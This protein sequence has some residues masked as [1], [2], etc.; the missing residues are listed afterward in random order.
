MADV[1]PPELPTASPAPA[2]SSWAL[3]PGAEI[4][5]G[6]RAVRRLGGGTLFEVYRAWD[7]RRL[8]LVVCKMVRPDQVGDGRALRQL[9]R[10]SGLLARLSHPV[11]VRSLGSVL[12]GPRPHLIL[13]H[14][15]KATLRRRLRVRGPL[16]VERVLPL[17]RQLGAALH[18]LSTQ[19]VVHLDVKPSNVLLGTPP[20]LIDLSIARSIDRARRLQG[21]V[22]TTNYMAPEQCLPAEHGPVGAAA[23]VWGLG[24]TVY[25]ALA[26]RLPFRS[27]ASGD[28]AAPS[29]RYPQ[30]S[31]AARP[32]PDTFP[33]ALSNL[34]MRCLQ[35]DPASRPTT[36]EFIAALAPI[37][38]SLPGGP[39]EDWPAAPV[40][41]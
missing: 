20:R 38:A 8:S 9:R 29:D 22:G 27:G 12:E 31:A 35:R 26:G 2:K 18:Y 37:A 10:E 7:E 1:A 24:V 21:P 14:I 36:G 41:R 16:P 5:P 25:E 40:V 13:E 15:E 32:L 11:I 6:F 3:A 17:A 34:V 33:L 39:L 4:A 19:D 28:E 30:L 23:D